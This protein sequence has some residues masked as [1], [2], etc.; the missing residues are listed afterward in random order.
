MGEAAT[1]RRPAARAAGEL[2]PD[3][4]AGPRTRV[5]PRARRARRH[6]GDARRAA[7]RAAHARPAPVWDANH[8]GVEGATGADARALAVS[9]AHHGVPSMVVVPTGGG[10]AARPAFRAP[11]ARR[12][13]L[14]HGAPRRPAPGRG[15]ARPRSAP[16]ARASRPDRGREWGTREIAEQVL[17]FER[18]L[19]AAAASDRWLTAPA[20]VPSPR[21]SP[22]RGRR[23]RPG[24]GR[25]HRP[26][27]P[28]AGARARGRGRG[29]RRLA[30]A[31]HELTFLNCDEKRLGV[32][33]LRQPR[34]RGDQGSCTTSIGP[35]GIDVKN[36]GPSV[37]KAGAP[38]RPA[39]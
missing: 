7:H 20:A 39:C 26:R 37:A 13:A 27:R 34:V 29:R 14:L 21:V 35:E 32:R 25:G 24:R 11:L 22:A 1:S 10:R 8:L 4:R 15:W 2:R 36:V 16:R 5:R 31:R 17:A 12:A 9:A 30:R 23:D 3:E 6:R 33:L 19:G 38:A 18:R 28:P